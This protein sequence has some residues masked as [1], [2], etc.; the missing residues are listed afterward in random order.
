L[1]NAY[2]TPPSLLSLNSGVNAF[3]SFFVIWRCVVNEKKLL[4]EIS[5]I[6]RRSTSFSM[7]IQEL[8][9]S[10][11]DG[12]GGRVL[13][14]SAPDK[15]ANEDRALAEHAEQIFDE[16]VGLPYRS[17]YSVSLRASGRE[18]GKLVASFALGCPQETLTQRLANFAGEQLG[19][20][21][22]R[23]RLTRERRKL[24]HQLL[25]AREAHINSIALQRAEGIL[26]DRRGMDLSSA[27]LW[28]MSEVAEAGLSRR[29]VAAKV[30]EEERLRRETQ[31]ANSRYRKA[32]FRAPRGHEVGRG[33]AWK[34]SEFCT[35]LSPRTAL[36]QAAGR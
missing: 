6:G 1:P 5:L 35:A 11:E 26:I 23:I 22:E 10:L 14:V 8:S 19:M 16:I 29:E 30:I 33:V 15:S 20:L 34:N 32:N 21:L 27:R 2:L 31:P 25:E 18:L 24:L 3:P 12:L 7:A 9:D 28:I 4:L 36:E 13:L 17:I